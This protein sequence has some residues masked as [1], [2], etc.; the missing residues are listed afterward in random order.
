MTSWGGYGSHE[1]A[2]VDPVGVVIN[3]GREV[4]VADH[5]N[6]R[7]QKFD[8]F[9]NFDFSWGSNGSAEN[10]FIDIAGIALG[11]DEQVYVADRTAAIVASDYYNRSLYQRKLGQTFQAGFDEASACALVVNAELDNEYCPALN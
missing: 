5:G 3:P 6:H 7:I 8:S 1:G 4:F 10:Q 2:F 11:A 9:G